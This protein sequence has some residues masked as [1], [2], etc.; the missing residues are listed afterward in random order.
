MR[1]N[2]LFNKP[3]ALLVNKP[4]QSSEIIHEDDI[5]DLQN[6]QIVNGF[7]IPFQ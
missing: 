7:N 3:S 2:S 4:L 6:S 1:N 5:N